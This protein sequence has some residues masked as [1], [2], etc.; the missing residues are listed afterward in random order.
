MSFFSF[1]KKTKTPR[2][3]PL[4]F[5]NTLSGRVEI[6]E[7]LNSTVRM[8]SC[9]PTVYDRVHIGNLRSYV[10]ADVLRRALDAWNY[11]V[12]QVINIT[13]VGHLVS[14]A[15]EG[16]DKVEASARKTGRRAQ[17]ITQEV[18][19]WWFEDLDALGI[20]RKKIE[21]PRATDYIAEQ[22]AL[23][24]TLEQKGYAYKISDGL[25]FDTAKSP[26]YGK[27]GGINLR[28]QQ[29]GARVEENREKKNSGD[30]ALW[31]FSKPGEKRQQEW[32]SPWGVGF[33]GWHIECT[34]FI[35]KLLG[36]Q[37][38][39]HTGGVDHIPIHHNNE[40]AQAQALTGKQYV[41]Y[42]MHNE[43]ITIEGKKIS[44]SLG[45]TV[46]LR[47]I[48]DRGFSP[49]ALRYWYMNGHYRTPMNFTW[50]ALAGADAALLR[51]RRLFLELPPSSFPP[52]E[53]FLR[54]FY[55]AIAD[56]LDTPRA[57][58][59]VWDLVRDEEISPAV[60]RVSLAEADR[61]LAL[62]LADARPSVKLRV[63]ERQDLPEEVR[64]LVAKREVARASRDFAK[65][66][67]LRNKLSDLG[68]T[69]EDTAQGP[70]ITKK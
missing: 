45:N 55:A 23:V 2:L 57:L 58:A 5:R 21:F 19:E 8:Y 68:Y 16:E 37:I 48:A 51:L 4:R 6:F 15:D 65:A 35:F 41:K 10:F 18:T 38:D 32:E 34:A 14:D 69:I 31:K 25:Y 54:D 43:F 27:L 61:I 59:R 56:D 7:P 63:I 66:D 17:E 26:G 40:L 9:G 60:K 62:G 67:G 28:G 47:T 20:E 29:A 49:R 50:D 53:K 13:D 30:F 36:K 64:Q 42:W 70:K 22:L 24:K 1:F 46:Y 12:K 39:I 44:K 3:P 33:P 11:K 52:D